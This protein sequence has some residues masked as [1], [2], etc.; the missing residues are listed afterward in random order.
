[1][2]ENIFSNLI[3]KK[4]IVRSVNAGVFFGTLDA[5]TPDG[6]SCE[7][8]RARKLWYWDGAAAVEEIAQ[9]GT[10][11]PDNCKFTV[12]VDKIAIVGICQVVPATD[13]AASVIESVPEWKA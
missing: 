4:V 3:G 7:L 8:S 5:I 12:T 11:R 2:S 9:I 6:C 10:A 13:K 1:M